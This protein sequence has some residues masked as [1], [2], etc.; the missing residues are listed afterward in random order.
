VL[1]VGRVRSDNC[2][3][4]SVG[5]ADRVGVQSSCIAADATLE[6]QAAKSR[7]SSCSRLVRRLQQALEENRDGRQ[8]CWVFCCTSRQKAKGWPLRTYHVRYL[9]HVLVVGHW[10]ALPLTEDRLDTLWRELG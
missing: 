5:R 3:V 1:Q 8:A 9:Y 7:Q 4:R 6:A 2:P 10:V